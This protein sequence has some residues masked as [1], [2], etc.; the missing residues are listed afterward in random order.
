MTVVVQIDGFDK[1]MEL[2]DPDRFIREIDRALQVSSSTLRDMTKQMP[3]VSAKRTGLSAIGLPVDTGRMRQSIRSQKTGFL[4]YEVI[5]D[6]NYSGYV[7][8]G[9]SRMPER[10]FFK[11]LL[12]DFQGKSTIEALVNAA[13]QR[14]V[15]P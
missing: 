5:A 9:T 13:L 12:E 15:T 11:W 3:P 8:D 10:P 1:F 7:H 6:V 14:V 4:D 2:L